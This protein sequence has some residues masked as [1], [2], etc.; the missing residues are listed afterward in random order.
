MTSPWNFYK[1]SRFESYILGLF[2]FDIL[3]QGNGARKSFAGLIELV[4]V[5]AL[6]P[7]HQTASKPY[8]C[9]PYSWTI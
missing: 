8:A 1:E 5:K 2:N 3:W 7:G 9:N 4:D 6:H